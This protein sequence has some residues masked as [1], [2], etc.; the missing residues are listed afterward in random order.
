VQPFHRDDPILIRSVSGSTTSAVRRYFDMSDSARFPTSR[1]RSLR[2]RL[3]NRTLT[4]PKDF[5]RIPKASSQSTTRGGMARCGCRA[6]ACRVIVGVVISLLPSLRAFIHKRFEQLL[7]PLGMLRLN[8]L[9][10]TPRVGFAKHR[11]CFAPRRSITIALLL[12]RAKVKLAE[13]S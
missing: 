6:E 10:C 2:A 4:A 13:Q 3:S 11:L 1:D 5:S 7:S 8:T 9:S 12:V